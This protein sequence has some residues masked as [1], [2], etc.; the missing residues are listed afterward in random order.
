MASSFLV[1]SKAHP[2]RSLLSE[3]VSRSL[4]DYE[5]LMTRYNLYA[6]GVVLRT[7]KW[8]NFQPGDKFSERPSAKPN[9]AMGAGLLPSHRQ[10]PKFGGPTAHRWAQVS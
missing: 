10:R 3:S 4:L 1:H 6:K 9:S 8:K 2:G 5:L 7:R